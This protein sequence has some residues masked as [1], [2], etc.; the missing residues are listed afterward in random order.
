MT[1]RAVYK[2]HSNINTEETATSEFLYAPQLTLSI[3][4]VELRYN[5]VYWQHTMFRGIAASKYK[6]LNVYSFSGA[7]A[8]H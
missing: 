8:H 4:K 6:G 7:S 3:I 5:N 2:T 1:S